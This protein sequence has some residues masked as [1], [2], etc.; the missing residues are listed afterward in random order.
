MRRGHPPSPLSLAWVLASCH[1]QER[2]CRILLPQRCWPRRNSTMC[3]GCW[4]HC[5]A[6]RHGPVPQRAQD[7][8]VLQQVRAATKAFTV[9]DRESGVKRLSMR[10]RKCL[11][12]RRCCKQAQKEG[13]M[14]TGTGAGSSGVQQPR[15]G[16]QTLWD[17]N[18]AWSMWNLCCAE[19]GCARRAGWL[20]AHA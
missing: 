7:H 1:R 8:C 9:W 3:R 2:G 12:C 10:L 4:W 17:L 6:C 14:A 20:S 16:Y 19:Y 13:S 11:Q 5:W 15:R 18:A